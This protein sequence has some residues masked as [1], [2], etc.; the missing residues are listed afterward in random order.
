MKRYFPMISERCDPWRLRPALPTLLAERNDLEV[1]GLYGL[2]MMLVSSAQLNGQC[3]CAPVEAQ[4]RLAVHRL[5]PWRLGQELFP[6]P[7]RSVPT[8]WWST[9]SN[10]AVPCGPVIC[11]R[12][13]YTL[14]DGSS[15][16]E[17]D[18]LRS[19]RAGSAAFAAQICIPHEHNI[20]RSGSHVKRL[21]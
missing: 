13:S 4:P 2:V 17:P 16:P 5:R 3:L 1:S 10:R 6:S 21:A 19:R 20:T 14:V 7:P 15:T 18:A 8:L 12:P 11:L 9:D